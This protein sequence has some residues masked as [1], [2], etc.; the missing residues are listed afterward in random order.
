MAGNACE[1]KDG[2]IGADCFAKVAVHAICFFFHIWVMVALA[3]KLVG[4]AQDIPR[5]IFYAKSAALAL[6]NIDMK[7]TMG[8]FYLVYI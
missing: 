3:V 2:E 8:N 4:E 7:F 5:A 6:L 1:A